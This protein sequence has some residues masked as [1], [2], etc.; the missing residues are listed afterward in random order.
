MT[1]LFRSSLARRRIA[2]SALARS[3]WD[4]DLLKISRATSYMRKRHRWFFV[5]AARH[6][7][8]VDAF[9]H[10][11]AVDGNSSIDLKAQPHLTSADF[12]HRDLEDALE[13]AGPSDDD[14][15]LIFPGQDQHG[16]TSVL[17]V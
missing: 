8:G 12:E 13:A 2:L 7:G 4:G 11:R 10:L 1:F 15:F 14:G 6:A 17:M 5:R 9:P 3:C 16:R